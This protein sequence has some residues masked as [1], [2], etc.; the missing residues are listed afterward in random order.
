MI[1]FGESELMPLRLIFFNPFEGFKLSLSLAGFPP[2]VSFLFLASS[3]CRISVKKSSWG[4]AVCR[5]LV[6]GSSTFFSCC[7]FAIDLANSLAILFEFDWFD[8]APFAWLPFRLSDC[9]EAIG[10]GGGGA[11]FAGVVLK[12]PIGSGGGGGALLLLLL[13]YS[14]GKKIIDISF[15]VFDFLYKMSPL[16]N[17]NSKLQTN[18]SSISNRLNSRRHIKVQKENSFFLV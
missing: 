13:C 4:G 5:L 1:G 10:G 11:P 16:W 6:C 14:N 18:I 8:S 7:L 17:M 3:F 12:R 2:A 9:I 15:K